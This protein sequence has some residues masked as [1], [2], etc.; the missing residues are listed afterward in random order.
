MIETK[1][2]FLPYMKNILIFLVGISSL[3]TSFAADSAA[4]QKYFN[5]PTVTQVSS[6]SARFFLQPIV[7]SGMTDEEKSRVYFEYTRT[8]MACPAIYP[9]PEY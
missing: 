6:S 2:L 5:G 9:V 8:N 7:L 1:L 4:T 3:A